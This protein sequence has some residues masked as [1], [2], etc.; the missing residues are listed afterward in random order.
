M[1]RL[2]GF[3]FFKTFLLQTC[4]VT[5]C[6]HFT[7]Y[8]RNHENVGLW[9]KGQGVLCGIKCSSDPT[10][11]GF[12]IPLAPDQPC[13]FFND[14]PVP[15]N[16]TNKNGSYFALVSEHWLPFENTAL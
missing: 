7:V 1:V 3:L 15:T 12:F 8:K 4:D 9:D 11:C 13:Q 6:N 2:I 16:A 5:E 10:C 14:E